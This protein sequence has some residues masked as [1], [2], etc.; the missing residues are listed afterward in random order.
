VAVAV[1][2]AGQ[3]C[4]SLQIDTAQFFTGRMPLLSPNKQRQSAEG[5][6]LVRQMRTKFKFV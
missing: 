5:K 3:V 4:T 1:A 2:S 6:V